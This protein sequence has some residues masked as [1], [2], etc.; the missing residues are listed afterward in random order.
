VIPRNRAG[1][2]AVSDAAV[3]MVAVVIVVVG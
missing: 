3:A 2:V 1:R